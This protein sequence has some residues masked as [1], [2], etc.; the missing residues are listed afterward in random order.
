MELIIGLV[1]LVA[2]I[3]AIIQVAGSSAD[4]GKKALWIIILLL[5]GPIGVILW[6]FMG[7]GSPK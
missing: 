2:V 5:L 7:P 3:W 4:G 6:Y 1:I